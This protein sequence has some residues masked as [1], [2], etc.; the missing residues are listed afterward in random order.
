[1]ETKHIL[2]LGCEVIYLKGTHTKDIEE[3]LES[4]KAKQITG[5]N[6]D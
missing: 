1:M 4:L 3:I 5:E 6:N 2:V